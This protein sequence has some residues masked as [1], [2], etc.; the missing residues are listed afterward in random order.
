[1]KKRYTEEQIIKVIKEHEAGAKVSDIC[2]RLGIS[3]GTF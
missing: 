2:R 1:M 3:N